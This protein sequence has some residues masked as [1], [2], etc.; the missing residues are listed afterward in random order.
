[1]ATSCAV[2]CSRANIETG[3]GQWFSSCRNS[4]SQCQIS[5]KRTKLLGKPAELFDIIVLRAADDLVG[6]AKLQQLADI[7]V[8]GPIRVSV[9]AFSDG[10]VVVASVSIPAQLHPLRFGQLVGCPR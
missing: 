2:R 5:R 3:I 4:K 10:H 1:M 6:K 8:L 7:Q 9:N